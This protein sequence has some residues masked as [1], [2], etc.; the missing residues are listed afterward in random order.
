MGMIRIDGAR[1]IE[2]PIF[3]LRCCDLFDHVI[4]IGFQF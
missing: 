2:V 3:F 1:R 4:D